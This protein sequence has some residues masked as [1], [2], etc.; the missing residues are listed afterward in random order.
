MDFKRNPGRGWA[1]PGPVKTHLFPDQA[2]TYYQ[3]TGFFSQFE[4]AYEA[5]M[6]SLFYLGPLASIRNENTAGQEQDPSMSGHVG[7]IALMRFS[8]LPQG[9]KG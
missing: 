5:L 3:N 4:A 6:D 2:Q 8:R 7:N 1:L 9:M